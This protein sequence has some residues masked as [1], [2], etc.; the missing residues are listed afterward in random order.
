MT[1]IF[2]YINLKFDIK[3]FSNPNSSII[4]QSK[5]S[6]AATA[7]SLIMSSQLQSNIKKTTNT[8]TSYNKFN[9]NEDIELK[10]K[11]HEEKIFGSKYNNSD[12]NFAIKDFEDDK[13]QIVCNIS[14]G[15]A[16]ILWSDARIDFIEILA[17]NGQFM[18]TIPVSD[19]K[20][21][22]MNDL[23]NGTYTLVFKSGNETL[24]IKTLEVNK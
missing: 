19:A 14:T 20:S 17:S 24:Y 12:S 16:T 4:Q 22:H 5:N 13:I 8:P 3:G 6:S 23:M 9:K 15:N 7:A 11:Q 10:R 18:P 2:I 21:L 1:Y